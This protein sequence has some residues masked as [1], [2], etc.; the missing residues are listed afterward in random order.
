MGEKLKLADLLSSIEQ[1]QD[2][3]ADSHVVSSGKIKKDIKRMAKRAV[4][5][6]ALI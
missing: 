6:G 2:Q 1:R 3:A 4:V 5:A